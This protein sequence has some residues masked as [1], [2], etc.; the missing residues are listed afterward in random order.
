[1][2]R[3]I[4]DAAQYRGLSGEDTMVWLAFEALKGL[5]YFKAQFLD[6]A[7]RE[8]MPPFLLPSSKSRQT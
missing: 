6:N 2:V 3:A 1:M 5:E 7:M 4:F 8:P